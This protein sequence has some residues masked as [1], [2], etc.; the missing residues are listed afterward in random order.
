MLYSPCVRYFSFL[1]SFAYLQRCFPYLRCFT[2]LRLRY[3]VCLSSSYF[4][5]AKKETSLQLSTIFWLGQK[6]SVVGIDLN[7]EEISHLDID[8]DFGIICQVCLESLFL[9]LLLRRMT[10]TVQIWGRVNILLLVTFCSKPDSWLKTHQLEHPWT[11][12]RKEWE[13]FQV[14]MSGSNLGKWGK[15]IVLV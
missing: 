1:S 14:C 8:Y 5:F 2:C 11:E 15:N 13:S 7:S 4:S 9:F 6:T 3:C 12:C 10:D